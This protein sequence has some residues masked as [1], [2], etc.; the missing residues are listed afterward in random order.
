MSGETAAMEAAASAAPEPASEP[1]HAFES[2]DDAVAELGKVREEAAGWRTKY[3]P[4]RD[5][6]DG[7]DEGT[8]TFVLE[9]VR[10]LKSDNPDGVTKWLDLGAKMA[11]DDEFDAWISGKVP[12]APAAEPALETEGEP[13]TVD[14]QA[15]VAQAVAEALAKEREEREQQT[16]EQETMKRAEELQN[17][18]KELGYTPGTGPY[19]ALFDVAMRDGVD[20]ATA[21]ETLRAEFTG[22]K[23]APRVPGTAS[24]QAQG[25]VVTPEATKKLSAAEKLASRL[26][27]VEQGIPG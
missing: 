14:V 24:A 20:L 1:A 2:V 15:T 9:A 7:L 16:R 3:A 27:K 4:F 18:A 19:S 10:D 13:E 23:E 8:V 25:G 17:Q 26:D 21:S 12:A 11:R 5:T 22:G 6:F